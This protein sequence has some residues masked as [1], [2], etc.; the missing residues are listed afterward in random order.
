MRTTRFKSEFKTS[1]TEQ[2]GSVMKIMLVLILLLVSG[3]S[4]AGQNMPYSL[5]YTFTA[6]TLSPDGLSVTSTSVANTYGSSGHT[7]AALTMLRSPGGRSAAA[8]MYHDYQSSA[9]TFLPICDNWGCEDGEWTAE[10]GGEEY[11]PI[12]MTTMA[13]ASTQ[14]RKTTPPVVMIS[15]VWVDKAEIALQGDETTLFIRAHK[16]Q[17]CLGPVVLIGSASGRLP[18]MQ[19]SLVPASG[20]VSPQWEN[21]SATGQVK[22]RTASTNTVAG[23]AYA[24]GGVESAPGCEWKGNPLSTEFTVRR[25]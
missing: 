14:D 1:F 23:T 25:E 18:G 22:I 17:S 6:I 15:H 4:A 16:S 13:V 24:T 7:A 21:N 20:L 8:N 19:L 10:G 5:A 3:W 2:G 11:C 12:A 9:T